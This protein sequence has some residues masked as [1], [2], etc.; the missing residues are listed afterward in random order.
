M[1]VNVF[2]ILLILLFLRPFAAWGEVTPREREKLLQLASKP[3]EKLELL[4]RLTHDYRHEHPKKT[5]R[6]GNRAL[7]I[8]REIQ[9][10][11]AEMLVY[12]NL[13]WAYKQ[14]G[15]YPE[16]LRNSLD[17]EI[18][19]RRIKSRPFQASVLAV[20]GSIYNENGH[21]REALDYTF[22]ALKIFRNIRD[23]EGIIRSYS[24]LGH[25]YRNMNEYPRAMEYFRKYLSAA[26]KNRNERDMAFALSNLGLLH[27]DSGELQDALD[28][29]TRSLKLFEKKGM[30]MGKAVVLANLGPLYDKLGRHDRAL[31]YNLQAMKYFEAEGNKERIPR[32]LIHISTSYRGLRDF[33]NSLRCLEQALLATSGIG[34]DLLYRD[35]YEGLAD[36]YESSGNYEKA[37][38]YQKEYKRISAKNHKEQKSTNVALLEV[39]YD[40]ETKEREIQLLTHRA[41]VQKLQLEKQNLVAKFLIVVSLL[42]CIIALVTYSRFLTKKR[43]ERMLRDSEAALKETN[44]AKDRLFTIIAHDLGS[45][46]NS[47]HLSAAHLERH[48]EH[49]D[50]TETREFIQNIYKQ[51]S[52]MSD[53]LENLLEW[54]MAQ[55]GKM[56]LHPEAVDLKLLAD[57]AV[58]QV[59]YDA[60]K[61]NIHISSQV[62]E[63]TV[64]WADRRMMNAVL[65]NLVSNAVKFTPPGGRVHIASVQ[66][67]GNI[68]L[69]I[70]DNGVGMDR[71][72]L[73]G[74]FK[75][76]L[77]ESTPGTAGEKGSGLGLLLCKEFV[78][79]NKGHIEVESQP[80]QGSRFRIILPGGKDA[81]R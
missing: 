26:E 74:L 4:V 80:Q 40:V 12:Y 72:K 35:I 38:E 54:A 75:I 13:G 68:E 59:S 73:R 2:A 14:L 24:Y 69:S 7:E 23:E 62:M 79:K 65:R 1:K 29:Y 46:L 64:A 10:H 60:E 6:Y 66:N 41:N 28:C 52:T 48:W 70:D 19:A 71:E 42:V 58:A 55:L 22:K 45:P 63:N 21:F 31:K 77:N 43:T 56:K 30:D 32:I 51:S 36:T 50:Q 3:E 78:E 49:L 8:L 53:L 47:L 57:E 25:I 27:Y 33:Q 81:R 18:L 20:L 9:D 61:K 44:T 5:V 11:E 17:A 39:K 34:S 37:L 67:N 16:A 15:N 76:E